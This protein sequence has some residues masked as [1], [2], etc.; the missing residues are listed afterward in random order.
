MADDPSS[1]NWLHLLWVAAIG[2]F[3]KLWGRVEDKSDKSDV[4]D[5]HA[6]NIKRLDAIIEKQDDMH[7][8]M[9]R[10]RIDISVVKQRLGFLGDERN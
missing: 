4:D 6:D 3:W 8:Q 2:A 1:L 10:M 9:T 7:E 5:K